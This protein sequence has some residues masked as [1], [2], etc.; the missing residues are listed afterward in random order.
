[1]N[2]IFNFDSRVLSAF[3]KNVENIK[4]FAKVARS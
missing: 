1:M 4:D 2:K 3:D